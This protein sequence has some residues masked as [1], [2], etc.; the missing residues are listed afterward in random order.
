MRLRT[1]AQTALLTSAVALLIALSVA[2][3]TRAQKASGSWKAGVARVVITPDKPI[4]MAGY[5]NRPK[6]S[7]TTC[8]S[9]FSRSK[10]QRKTAS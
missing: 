5:A 2:T 1:H 10:T 6:A 9:K 8:S 3:E 4:W 7:S